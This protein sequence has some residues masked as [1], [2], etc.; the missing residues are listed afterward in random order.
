MPQLCWMSLWQVL[1][2]QLMM[3][4]GGRAW[5]T[6]WKITAGFYVTCPSPVVDTYA[7]S[8]YQGSES[9][10]V[11]DCSSKKNVLNVCVELWE[12]CLVLR[13]FQ[14]DKAALPS[15]PAGDSPGLSVCIWKPEIDIKCILKSL[16][17][18]FI[19]SFVAKV[20]HWSVNSRDLSLCALPQPLPAVMEFQAPGFY[21][22]IWDP[23]SDHVYTAE[24]FTSWAISSAQ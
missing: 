12:L 8:G 19:H 18:S 4:D 7:L 24:H 5:N 9:V 17:H 14:H 23:T 11:E 2:G 20:P 21:V 1:N 22:D 15:V 16:L 6:T 10:P 13:E 3:L